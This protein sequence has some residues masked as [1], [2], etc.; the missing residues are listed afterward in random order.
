MRQVFQATRARTPKS[1]L[2]M[3]TLLAIGCALTLGILTFGLLT[4]AK[5]DAKLSQKGKAKW[6]EIYELSFF[7]F[8][9]FFFQ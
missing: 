6:K 8:F 3:L 7:F 2:F 1:N 4:F 9:K 5:G